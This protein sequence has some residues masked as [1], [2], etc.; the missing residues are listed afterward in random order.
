MSI[1]NYKF[2]PMGV[3]EAIAQSVVMIGQNLSSIAYGIAGMIHLVPSASGAELHSVVGVVGFGAKLIGVGGIV[4]FI[5]LLTFISLNL[6]VFNILPVPMLDGG[7]LIFLSI[8]NLRGKP[9]TPM[10]QGLIK[11]IFAFLLLLVLGFGVMN[12]FMHPLGS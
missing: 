10:T 8:E 12:D 9:L 7:Y 11:I 6:A 3:N 4:I 5:Y 1:Q 2:I